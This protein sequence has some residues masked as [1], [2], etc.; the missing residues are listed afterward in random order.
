MNM[1]YLFLGVNL[2]FFDKS[3]RSID[4]LVYYLNNYQTGLNIG[5]NVITTK[6]FYLRPEVS[7]R[8]T[9]YRVS[10]DL[11][12][13][14]LSVEEYEAFNPL[15]Y[16]INHFKSTFGV[17]LGIRVYD[18]RSQNHFA[19]VYI[20]SGYIQPLHKNSILRT[21]NHPLNYTGGVVYKKFLRSL[22]FSYYFDRTV[23]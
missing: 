20:Y 23:Y 12:A 21:K 6:Y 14:R 18:K 16:R 2:G 15:D 22:S 7:L 8:H 5:V 10:N 3:D 4:S 1:D 17:K 9:R 13:R 11:K 19:S